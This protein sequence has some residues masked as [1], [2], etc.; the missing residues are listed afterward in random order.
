MF[1]GELTDALVVPDTVIFRVIRL[2][3]SS[4][5]TF[6]NTT[7]AFCSTRI[8]MNA[9]RPIAMVDDNNRV[10]ATNAR[11]MKAKDFDNRK[12]KK[13]QYLLFKYVWEHIDNKN[14]VEQRNLNKEA[15]VYALINLHD[16][17]CD[18]GTL[19]G[20]EKLCPVQVVE[21]I[22]LSKRHRGSSSHRPQVHFVRDI[23]Y[24]WNK[25]VPTVDWENDSLKFERIVNENIPFD[26]STIGEVE[27]EAQETF[28]SPYRRRRGDD[29]TM[30][31]F[32]S[33]GV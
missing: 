33:S 16:E 12:H 11:K 1:L 26:A 14:V 22:P 10:I 20:A 25:K 5:F 27:E 15:F 30:S 17:L 7:R 6:N 13:L 3:S 32:S 9:I 29:V 28:T 8:N 4:A 19:T 24:S 21:Q 18:N 2:A 31:K 23:E